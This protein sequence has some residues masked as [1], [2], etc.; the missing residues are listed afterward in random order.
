MARR[1][2]C[3]APNMECRIDVAHQAEW[4]VVHVAGRLTDAQIPDLLTV[5]ATPELVRLDLTE[6]DSA[7]GVAV[8]VLRRL[9]KAGAQIVGAPRII[10]LQIDVSPFVRE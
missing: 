1:L 5:C 9:Q 7:S 10:Q 2:H 8:E 3:D 6:L 4:C